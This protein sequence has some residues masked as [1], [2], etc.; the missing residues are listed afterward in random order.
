MGSIILPAMHSVTL[1]H[2]ATGRY[3][4]VLLSIAAPLLAA[5]LWSPVATGQGAGEDY[6]NVKHNVDYYKYRYHPTY[7]RDGQLLRT[8][9]YHHQRLGADKIRAG[10]YGGAYHEFVFVLNVF[11]NHPEAL[12]GLDEACRR[13]KMAGCNMEQRFE[14]AIAVNP[15]AAGTY[16]VQGI[17]L[18]R[19]GKNAA[20]IE[21]YKRAIELQPESPVAHYNL[22]LAY[23]ETKDYARANEHAQKAYALGFPLP[24][25]RERLKKAGQW[26]PSEAPTAVAPEKGA[27]APGGT[28]PPSEQ[29]AAAASGDKGPAQ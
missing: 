20:A 25:L 19:N 9:E 21:S 7:T 8:V 27:D 4:S 28:S 18:S 24:G 2:R 16:V 1:R 26:K 10:N 6:F 15:E 23:V 14:K 22:G 17:Y 12:R 29:P 11:P 13:V 3:R 5:L